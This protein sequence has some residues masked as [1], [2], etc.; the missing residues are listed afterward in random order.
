MLRERGGEVSYHDPYVAE[1]PDLGL[2]SVELGPAV[3]GADLAA[4]ITA[5]P[6]IDYGELVS[7]AALVVDFR[8]VTRGLDAANLIRL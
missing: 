2:R 4:V 5:H 3:A 6:E 8:G 1:L 7:A